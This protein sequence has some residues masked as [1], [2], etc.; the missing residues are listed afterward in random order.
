MFKKKKKK[1]EQI[2]SIIAKKK[3]K[4]ERER[5]E[6]FRKLFTYSLDHCRLVENSNQ[7][8]ILFYCNEKSVTS[9]YFFVCFSE[10]HS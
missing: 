1:E 8:N 7:Q 4:R 3:R 10:L 2:K 5:K 6:K 9:D